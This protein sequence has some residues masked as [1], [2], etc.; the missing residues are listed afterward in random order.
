MTSASPGYE[1]KGAESVPAKT[2]QARE[3]RLLPAELQH[4]RATEVCRAAA[5]GRMAIG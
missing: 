1:A 4:F 2:G 5:Q 3:E